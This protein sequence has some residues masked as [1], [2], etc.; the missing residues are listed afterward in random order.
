MQAVTHILFGS[1]QANSTDESSYS[2]A[3]VKHTVPQNGVDNGNHEASLKGIGESTMVVTL[4]T[5]ENRRLL[6]RI[7][8]YLVPVFLF[9]YIFQVLDKSALSYS[10]IM[11]L[12]TDLKLSGGDYSWASSIYYFGYLGFSYPAS[13]LIVR[14]P[15]GKLIA[16]SC[17]VWGAIVMTTAG[18]FN[19]G[20]LLAARFFLGAAESTIAPGLAVVVSMWYK[21][22]EQP[23]RHAAWFMGNIL[24][25]LFGGVTFVWGL[26]L[27]YLMPDQ[28]STARFLN[29]EDRQKA[30]IRVSD[31]M[32]GI[33]NEEFKMSQVIEGLLDVKTLLLFLIMASMSLANGLA[34]FQSI[35]IK[36]FGFSTVHTYLIQMICTA[37]QAIFVL[38]G[39]VGST[40][41]KNSRTYFMM[42]N[43]LFGIAGAVMV[44]E[45]DAE[46]LWARFFGYCLCIAFSANFPLIFALSTGN[47]AGFTKK[48]T[49]NAVRA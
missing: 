22:S 38:I 7:D 42:L 3:E 35:V 21:K 48:A 46:R 44:N 33:K 28:P 24:F 19:A 9:S 37:F 36:G 20:G 40:Y 4:S 8:L 16:G 31:N 43:F 6:R 47:V 30:V 39:S 13:Y 25:I 17:M 27:I 45:I 15:V 10:T 18:C 1:A 23:L 32:T 11:G 12:R 2:M 49:V 14:Y 41:I 5:E 29:T 26:C 34:S